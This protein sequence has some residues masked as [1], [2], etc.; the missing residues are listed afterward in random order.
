M[1][2]HLQELSDQGVSIW[3][4]DISRQR[5]TSGNLADLVEKR[6]VVG[7]TS[8]PTIFAKAV[9]DADDYDEQVKDLAV[10]GVDLEEA[11]R[12]I[13]TYD[14]RWACDVLREAYDRDRR[15][16]RPGQHRG[17][18]APGPPHRGHHRR[19]ARAVVAGRP[20]RM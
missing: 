17:R 4:D 20:A 18:P 15:A 14:V 10:R 12:A 8:N 6:H 1:T 19:G 11:V 7:V 3:L 9:S 5:L 13:T 2:D 16:G